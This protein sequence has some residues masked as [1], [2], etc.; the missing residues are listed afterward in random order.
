MRYNKINKKIFFGLC[1]L[2]TFES[3]EP[4]V[5]V[6]VPNDRITGTTVFSDDQTALSA[7]NGLYS[8]LFNTSF[9]AGGN[10]SVTFLS[11]LSGDNFTM[12]SVTAEMVEFADNEIFPSNSFNLDLWSGAYNTIYMANALIEGAES[13]TVLSEA[14]RNRILGEAKFVRAFTYFYLVNLYDNVPLILTSD[15]TTNSLAPNV[16]S[17]EIY[18]QI[19]NDLNDSLELVDIAYP[20]GE[21]TFANSYAVMALLARVA[22]F[23]K[24]WEQAEHHSTQIITAGEFYKL[25]NDPN[26]LFLPN[27]QEAIWQIS[28]AGWGGSFRHTREGN[29]FVRI[30]SG[31]SPVT[32]SETFMD[33]WDD[34]DQRFINW[35]G[36]YSDDT[37]TYNYPNKYKVQYDAEGGDISEYSMVMRLAEQYLIRAEA[38]LRLGDLQGAIADIDAIRKRAAIPL[39]SET[40]PGISETRLLELILLERRRELFA[41]WGHRWLDLK[42]TDTAGDI[43]SDIKPLWESTD[44][45]YPIPEQERMKNPN[46]VQNEGY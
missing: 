26:E 12:T 32:L 23:Q 14:V 19:T 38:R 10:R 43:L 45:F 39:I 8:Q 42:R 31:N 16:T 25:L 11:G 37:G 17:E 5:E 13:S 27:S 33:V 15:Y 29:L 46:L 7:L 22:L 34:G 41:E 9:A 24:N 28:P 18:A 35:I 21:R 44:V 6:D 4:F 2:C 20:E 3:C 30:S 36:S 40:E 1:I